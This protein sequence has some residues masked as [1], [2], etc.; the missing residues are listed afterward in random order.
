MTIT[1]RRARILALSL[2]EKAADIREGKLTP[3]SGRAIDSTGAPVCAFG[4][5]LHAAARSESMTLV[6]AG[7][8]DV[9]LKRFLNGEYEL[10]LSAQARWEIERQAN[11]ISSCNDSSFA[12]DCAPN[13]F[14]RENLAD[15]MI[16]L[17]Q[18]L[19]LVAMGGSL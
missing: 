4:H 13:Q 8:N 1:K 9:A 18:Q 5:A 3:T 10:E 7:Y 16:K 19:E 15:T 2:R 11:V 14:D 17:A 6:E 12:I